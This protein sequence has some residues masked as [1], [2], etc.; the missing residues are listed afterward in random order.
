MNA[1]QLVSQLMGI[2]RALLAVMA[3]LLGGFAVWKIIGTGFNVDAKTA[4]E[5]A[6]CFAITYFCL[7]K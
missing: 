7:S 6:A 1:D 4:A 2:V 3:L 5:V